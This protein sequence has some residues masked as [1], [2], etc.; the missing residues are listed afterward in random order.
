MAGVFTLEDGLRLVAA[1]G[2]LMHECTP[3]GRMSAVFAPAERVAPYLRAH[4]DTLALAGDNAPDSVVIS[5]DPTALDEVLA[6]LHRDG[7]R[8]RPLAVSR[9]FHSPLMDPMLEE[10]R[11]VAQ[12]V[13]YRPPQWPIVSNLTAQVER[14]RLCDPGHWVAHL[15]AA[16]RFREGM[17]TLLDAGV[18][19]TLEV[20][21]GKVLAGLARACVASSG[22]AEPV[23]C[24]LSF[25]ARH[26][27]R[28]PLLESLAALWHG[29]RPVDWAAFE[30]GAAERKR[31]RASDMAVLGVAWAPDGA[32]LAAAGADQN[33]GMWDPATATE[34]KRL[35]GHYD[36]VQGVAFAGDLVV[37]VSDDRT[38]RVWDAKTSKE[39]RSLEGHENKVTCVAVSP[40]GTRALT[41]G[42]D[43][44]LLVWDLSA[45]R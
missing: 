29:G 13:P 33:V 8:T 31:W 1:R 19:S 16:V 15:R 37:T 34:G 39:R 20:G 7:L 41:T 23:S 28:R 5:G 40:D 14:E 43:A 35:F 9:A 4:A 44:T 27:E 42:K 11:R 30:L 17:S 36:D 12:A 3:P 6:E 10:F 21:P 24:L 18:R 26:D 32:R 22:V 2:R 45:L 25:E 38:V